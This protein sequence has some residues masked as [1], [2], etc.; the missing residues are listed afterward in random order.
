M[1]I[2]VA[3]VSIIITPV[4][5]KYTSSNDSWIK[6]KYLLDDKI[7]VELNT[8]YDGVTTHSYTRNFH[9]DGTIEIIRDHQID[10]VFMGNSE[11]YFYYLKKVGSEEY[12]TEQ[13]L[14]TI[15]M[16]KSNYGCGY[17]DKIHQ[18]IGSVT[19]TIYGAQIANTAS[20]LSIAYE[21]AAIL[22]MPIAPALY[23]A[24]NIL[25][26]CA[27]QTPYKMIITKNMYDVKQ[28]GSMEHL[29][30]CYHTYV[31]C[32]NGYNEFLGATETYYQEI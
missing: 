30:F 12:Y 16:I 29:F 3:I 8:Y 17:N 2:L 32:Y 31:S 28:P 24:A 18:F 6:V 5:A 7:V 25:D 20:A 23:L 15:S 14:V 13:S 19:N 22:N 11:T 26:L 27:N 9:L 1:A 21:I 10:E 4:N